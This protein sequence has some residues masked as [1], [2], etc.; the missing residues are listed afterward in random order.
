MSVVL[1]KKIETPLTRNE[2]EVRRE[3]EREKGKEKE[4]RE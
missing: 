4:A 2:R 1:T 3:W